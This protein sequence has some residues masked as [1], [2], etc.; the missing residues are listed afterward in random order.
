MALSLPIRDRPKPKF[1]GS[2]AYLVLRIWLVIIDK[3]RGRGA[4]LGSARECPIS[5]VRPEFEANLIRL[6]GLTK[7]CKISPFSPHVPG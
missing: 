4:N 1:F 6:G 7:N 3:N 5:F 2:S